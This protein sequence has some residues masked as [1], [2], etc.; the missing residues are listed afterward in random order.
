MRVLVVSESFSR[1]FSRAAWGTFQRMEMFIQA[2]KE[3]AALDILFFVPSDVD[4]SRSTVSSLEKTLADRWCAA[5]RLFLC[6]RRE[7]ESHASKWELYGRGILNFSKQSNCLATSGPQQI[8][9]LENYL[10]NKP[11]MVF[12]HRFASM[13]PLLLTRKALPRICFDLDDIEHTALLRAINQEPNWRDK[14]LYYAG[15]PALCWGEYRAIRLASLTFV[16]SDLD[17]D[18]LRT[19]WRLPGVFTVPNAVHAVELQKVAAESTVLFLGAL[20]YK[21]N[22]EAA[23]FL[24]KEIWPRVYREMPGARLIIAGNNPEN[25]Q[26]LHERIPRVEF[27]GFVS[28]LRGLYARSRVVCAPIL[29]GAGTRVKIIEA[30]MYGKPTV[31]TRIGAEGLEFRDGHELLLRDDPRSFANACVELLANDSL[32][33]RLGLAAHEA[34]VR[35]YSRPKI[36]ALIRAHIMAASDERLAP[37]PQPFDEVRSHQSNG[38]SDH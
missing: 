17:R 10:Q 34:A 21:P 35:Y 19:W 4:C 32:C 8:R 28:D 36:E 7:S 18:Y 37:F 33:E 29:S 31:A 20:N 2:I 5:I 30:A 26:G 14:L 25:I 6:P 12:A 27:T 1:D 11:D 24:L 13:I 38:Q 3:L 22:A 16:C 23:R 9:A 15:L